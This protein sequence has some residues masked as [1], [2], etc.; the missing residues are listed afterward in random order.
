MSGQSAPPDHSVELAQIQ[1][2]AADKA[3]AQQKADAAAAEAKFQSSLSNA[4]SN[5]IADAQDYFTQRGLNP[6]DYTNQITKMAQRTMASVPDLAGNPSTYFDSL[7]SQVAGNAQGNDISKFM[8]AINTFAPANFQN[9]AIG[10]NAAD[11]Y[12]SGILASSRS[13]ADEYLKNLLAR[14]V[15]TNAGLTA[16]EGNLDSQTDAARQQLIELAQGDIAG[17]RGKLTADAANAR[18]AASN[19]QLGDT[20]DPYGYSKTISDDTTSFFQ[21]LGSQ[22]RAAAP[23]NL[24][25]TTG[26]ANIAGAA[27]GAQNTPFDPAALAGVA[28]KTV[29]APKT[30]NA[31]S[32]F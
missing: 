20:F 8:S 24:F 13:S 28:D 7:G 4:Y 12:V 22:L 32:P 17:G 23:A 15:I 29:T 1:Q 26:L 25:S 2:T 3:A 31:A 19:Y 30:T 18:T 21:N 16:G 27:Q 6:D 11:P 9:S 10:D 5:A 14:G